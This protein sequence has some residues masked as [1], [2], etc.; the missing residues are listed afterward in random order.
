MRRLPVFPTLF[1]S[2][3]VATML[4]LGVWQLQRL[5][6]KQA[7]LARYAAAMEDGAPVRFPAA[8]KTEDAAQHRAAVEQALFHRAEIDCR[9]PA[10]E[11]QSIAG[12]NAAGEAGYVHL[13]QCALDDGRTAWVQA[14]WTRG[15]DHPDWTGGKVAGMIAP[16]TD[17]VARL[18]ADPPVAGFAASARPDP[19]DVPNNHLAYAVQWFFFAG[20]ALVI[21]ALALRKRWR[22]RDG[23]AQR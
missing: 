8:R 6:Q 3:A 22:E 7:L 1:V 10:G 16:Y 18:I 9:V 15:P 13:V 2:G 23:G 11:W 17:G 12:R 20:V 4:G 19:A 5:D 14:G 21:Y